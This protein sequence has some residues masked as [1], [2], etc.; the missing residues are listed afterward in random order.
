MIIVSLSNSVT[1]YTVTPLDLYTCTMMNTFL[2]V[3]VNE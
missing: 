2:S 1:V 3:F